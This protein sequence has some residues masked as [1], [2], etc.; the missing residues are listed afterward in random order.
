MKHEKPIE[1]FEV[2]M[3]KNPDILDEKIEFIESLMGAYGV[4]QKSI[5]DEYKVQKDG[6]KLSI[7]FLIGGI[8][9]FISP[10]M[11]IYLS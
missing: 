8:I 11:A 2:K 10:A 4:S 5:I 9:C 3:K 7:T 6:L 1:L